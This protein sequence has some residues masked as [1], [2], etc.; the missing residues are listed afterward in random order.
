MS[1]IT[2]HTTGGVYGL[3][4][5][6]DVDCLE[7]VRHIVKPVLSQH[8][9]DDGRLDAAI[10]AIGNELW[11]FI[12][13]KRQIKEAKALDEVNKLLTKQVH[14]STSNF[15]HKIDGTCTCMT[16]NKKGKV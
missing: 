6:I 1:K 8:I 14:A 9:N 4:H 7:L 15:K 12:E 13:S 10:D 3:H 5:G 11:R 16:T 2:V